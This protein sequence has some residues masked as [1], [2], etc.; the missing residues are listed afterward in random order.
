MPLNITLEIL[1]IYFT[2]VQSLL[3]FTHHSLTIPK[4]DLRYNYNYK[5]D[6]TESVLPKIYYYHHTRRYVMH[7][8]AV[9]LQQKNIT[10]ET[11]PIVHYEKHTIKNK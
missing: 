9:Y 7:R 10:S 1:F 2:A 6:F 3:I 11:C 4:K 5:V 8:N